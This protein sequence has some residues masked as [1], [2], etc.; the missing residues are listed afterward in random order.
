LYTHSLAELNRFAPQFATN[1]TTQLQIP[2]NI[3][4]GA[5][6]IRT[7]AS[8][9]DTGPD[10]GH[11]QY[12][13]VASPYVLPFGVSNGLGIFAIDSLSGL[14]TFAG[15]FSFNP[16]IVP[17]FLLTIKASDLGNPP[18]DTLHALNVV[19]VPT[20]VLHNL[21]EGLRVDEELLPGEVVTRLFC[22]EIGPPSH[23]TMVTLSGQDSSRFSIIKRSVLE[24]AERIDY[25]SLPE[26]EREFNITATCSNR[27]KQID[28]I[29]VMVSIENINDNVFQ[30]DHPRHTLLFHENVTVGEEVLTVSAS[31]KDSLNANITYSLETIGAGM[32]DFVI[33]PYTGQIVVHNSLDRETQ[34][35]YEITVH[36]A[37][38]N[39]SGLIETTSTAVT[40]HIADVNDESPIFGE[41]SY[42]VTLS[43]VP[44]DLVVVVSA[45]DSDEGSNG[46]ITYHLSEESMEF[47]INETTGAIYLNFPLTYYMYVL[48]ITA[49]DG[50]EDPRSSTA[51]VYIIDALYQSLR[52][53]TDDLVVVNEDTPIGSVISNVSYDV[54]NYTLNETSVIFEIVNRSV[55]DIFEI[56]ETN[57]DI[58]TTGSLDYETLA[59]EYDLTIRVT[60]FL[61]TYEIVDEGAV[62]IM[63]ENVDDTPPEFSR[64]LYTDRVEQFTLPNV[65]ILSVAAFDLDDLNVTRYFLSGDNSSIFQIDSLTGEVSAAVLLDAPQDYSFT[66]VAIDSGDGEANASVFISV[67]ETPIF[68]A[69]EFSFTISESALPGTMLGRVTDGFMNVTDEI[70]FRIITH[71]ALNVSGTS[72]V[73]INSLFYIDASSGNIT[74]L[75]ALDFEDRVEYLFSAEMYNVATE[76]VYYTATVEVQV[77]DENDN[78]P[79]FMQ[80]FYT[81]VIDDSQEPASIVT[82]VSATDRDAGSNGRIT[83]S[84]DESVIDE[85]EL[86]FTSGA[87]STVNFTLDPGLYQLTVVASDGGNMSLRAEATVFIEVIQFI[88]E[89]IEF[90]EL[91]Y[92]FQ[93]VE[94]AEIGTLIGI[95]QATDSNSSLTPPSLAYSW[96]NI[97]DCFSI[98]TESGE[99][100][101]SCTS[102]DR[103]SVSNYELVATAE[104]GN[105][106]TYTIVTIAVQDINDNAPEFSLGAYTVILNNTSNITATIIQVF[107]VDADFGDNGTV[108]YDIISRSGDNAFSVNSTSGEIFFIHDTLQVGD[109][110]L[111]IEATDLGTPFNMSSYTLVLIHVTNP[112]PQTLQFA[113]LLFNVTENAAN[114]SLGFALL[115]TIEGDSIDP[116]DFPDD[117]QFFIIGGDSPDL[118]FVDED[119]GQLRLQDTSLNH[120]EADEHVIEIQANF[121]RFSNVPVQSITSSFT[122]R[123]LDVNDNSPRILESFSTTIDDS[124]ESDQVLFNITATDIDS[125]PNAMVSFS[126]DLPTPFGVRATGSDLPFTYGEIFINDTDN[127]VARDYWFNLAA[128]DNGMPSMRSTAVVHVIVE[129]A[130]PEV[131]RFSPSNYTFSILEESPEGSSVGNVSV[132]PDSPALDSLVYAITGGSGREFFSIDMDTG[133][134]QTRHRRLDRERNPMYH[135]NLQAF[136]PGQDPP[137]IAYAVVVINLQDVNDNVPTF[138]QSIYP[139]V[140]INTDDLN[141]TVSLIT[142]AATDIDRGPNA[143]VHYSIQDSNDAFV[144]NSTTG[145]L[146]PA[147]SELGLGNY[148]LTLIASDQGQPSLTGYAFA[149]ILVQRPAPVSVSFSNPLGYIFRLGEQSGPAIFAQ[150]ALSGIPEHLSQYVRYSTENG[151]SYFSIDSTSGVIS[152][153]R[154]FDYELDER[155]FSFQVMSTFIVPHRIPPINLTAL[156]NVTVEIAD[157]NDNTPHFVDFP[158]EI[159]TFEGETRNEV[160]YSFIAIDG[161]SD[162]NGELRY[163]L[164]SGNFSGILAVDTLSGQLTASIDL[165]REGPLES[166]AQANLRIRV[167]DSGIPPRCAE[168][169]TLFTILDINDNSPLL[170]SGDAYVVNERTPAQTNIFSFVGTDPDAGSN[171]TIRYYLTS[172]TPFT[173]NET[174]GQV[175]LTGELNFEEQSS[176]RLSLTLRDMGSP[177][178]STF[179]DNISVSVIDLPDSTPYFSQRSY[180]HAINATTAAS[181]VLFRVQ[182]SDADIGLSNDSLKYA[183]T[184]IQ[185]SRN[186]GFTPRLDVGES[187]GEIIS[188]TSQVFNPGAEFVIS[189]LVY[190]QSAFNLSNMTTIV[191]NVL[192]NSLAFIQA[193]HSVTIQEDAPPGSLIARLD[194]DPLSVAS[195]TTY[196]F[197]VMEPAL[198]PVPFTLTSNETSA[199]FTLNDEGGGLNREHIDRYVIEVTVSLQNESAL[200]RLLVIVADINDNSPVFENPPGTVILI[201]EDT[202]IHAIVTQVNANDP[203]IGE[204]AEINFHILSHRFD[205]PFEIDTR[206]GIIRTTRVLNGDGIFPTYNITVY[207]RDSGQPRLEAYL[208]YM[209]HITGAT[210]E[211][212]E[213]ETPADETSADTE[214]IRTVDDHVVTSAKPSTQTPTTDD[215]IVSP[216]EPSFTE[217]IDDPVVTSAK[218][219][220]STQTPTVDDQIVTSETPTEKAIYIVPVAVGMGSVV[221]IVILVTVPITVCLWIRK[222][223]KDEQKQKQK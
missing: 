153:L 116:S 91:M 77:E 21:A 68:I 109:Y 140:G 213:P 136:L 15:D 201:H 175:S 5:E 39:T 70:S 101:V 3:A 156:A 187:T 51:S 10:S 189:V 112:H 145:E 88:P 104:V 122:V 121:T 111:I 114:V 86:D 73:S 174:T 125:G 79:V 133:E 182:A 54:L 124:A 61:L 106:T 123:V 58:Y 155:E 69:E 2:W 148:H 137:L 203:D 84:F 197:S 129:H 120:E 167:C 161:D 1:L 13:L 150:V 119:N 202:A 176:Y 151:G 113:S 162:M 221:L 138:S 62:R 204:N 110:T 217:T 181:E 183:I 164:L 30:F 191:I 198:L 208:D 131:I 19:P 35:L 218:P 17:Q 80:S 178:L 72:N 53:I 85:F 23:S 222:R 45:T 159:T 34:A 8:D 64:S 206:M 105:V 18:L 142:V 48:N 108:E 14:I 7:V 27:Y 194:V 67:F 24:V 152:A 11:V 128:T 32:S 90:S 171:G 215:Q 147:S 220:E 200:S 44:G 216:A 185:V 20:L 118:F 98:D 168:N 209:I 169:T 166:Q 192:H 135:L 134:I 71:G 76:D 55:S 158:E 25:D 143:D 52:I 214:T 180:Q 199:I 99:I 186:G 196:T 38:I 87:I 65:T 95:V 42:N 50:G 126:I 81:R 41:S 195:D 141:T 63:I 94:D 97:T 56:N 47:E 96:P 223:Q 22:E 89:T 31:D 179:Y 102:L 149:S 74:T 100:S 170:T 57:G 83:Y 40:V 93:V 177:I 16:E 132:L 82:I 127:L 190:D 144:I 4:Q 117:L 60:L 130:I 154:D 26:R 157:V 66:V 28:S 103:E 12:S 49:I 146:Y 46:E 36:A 207:A 219:S 75:G 193:E 212:T 160:I 78:P 59:T 210:P 163:T 211:S 188:E 205:L 33:D 107:A 37:Y 173:C 139:S 9:N 172:T 43:N 184:G 92:Y 6:V 165:D 29:T 115:E